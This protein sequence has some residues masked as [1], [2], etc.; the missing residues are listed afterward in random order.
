MWRQEPDTSDHT[1]HPGQLCGRANTEQEREKRV[2]EV[3]NLFGN[4]VTTQ[5]NQVEGK[6]LT[7][8]FS[9]SGCP[10]ANRSSRKHSRSSGR[11]FCLS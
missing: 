1:G 4:D 10:E 6:L 5:G 7:L 11:I 2:Q 8:F 9:F 3:V